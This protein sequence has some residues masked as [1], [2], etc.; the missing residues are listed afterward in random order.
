MIHCSPK[1]DSKNT[2]KE[3]VQIAIEQ[4]KYENSAGVSTGASQ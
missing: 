3:M 2:L 1:A 4:I